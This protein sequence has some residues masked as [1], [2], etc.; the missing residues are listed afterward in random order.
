[1]EAAAAGAGIL[2]V[3][4]TVVDATGP[5]SNGEPAIIASGIAFLDHMVDQLT[6]HAQLRVSLRTWVDG[7]AIEPRSNELKQLNADG[8]LVKLV[9][10]ALGSALKAMLASGPRT[11]NST[12]GADSTLRASPATRFSFCA[13]LDEAFTELSLDFPRDS[14]TLVGSAE[15]DL[16][17]YGVYPRG[18]REFIGSFRTVLTKDFFVHLARSLGCGLHLRKVRGENAHHIVEASFKSFARCLRKAMDSLCGFEAVAYTAAP[19]QPRSSR[20]Q[21]STKETKIDVALE[22]DPA[23]GAALSVSTGI[24]TLDGLLRELV[25]SGG[26]GVSACCSGDTWIDE[27]HSAEDVMITVGKALADALGDKGGLN[28]MGCAEGECGRARVRCV[29]DLSNRP[30]FC[31]SLCLQAGGEEM[32][33][34]LSV[35]MI[36]HCFE[37][38][39]LNALMTVHLEQL[40]G[41]TVPGQNEPQ[42]GDVALA[43]A[44]ALGSALRQC[45]A[46]D[47]RRAGAT[48]SSK[49]TL[50]K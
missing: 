26:M 31:S 22:L 20:K 17:P 8:D 32:V 4:V 39:V 15:V 38:F 49:G 28:R 3:T 29:M 19:A 35:E 24:A 23:P 33:G 18:G 47:P 9:G 16:A 50:S 27:H 45:A 6:A 30:S 13:P 36:H 48:A 42:A 1:M 44:R 21:R 34:D 11:N 43:A 7:R 5:A 37:S 41:G 10:S 14:E 2:R 40:A 46:I 25:A 12:V